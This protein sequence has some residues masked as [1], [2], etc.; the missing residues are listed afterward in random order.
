MKDLL[1]GLIDYLLNEE[2]ILSK[3]LLPVLTFVAALLALMAL[4]WL[5]PGAPASPESDQIDVIRT[6]DIPK[7]LSPAVLDSY[8]AV[9][10][11]TTQPTPAASSRKKKA[12][13]PE[14]EKVESPADAI[15]SSL[16]GQSFDD[17]ALAGTPQFDGA[18]WA[19]ENLCAISRLQDN[20]GK[21]ADQARY[22]VAE[23]K[24][25]CGIF[26]RQTARSWLTWKFGGLLGWPLQLLA[27]LL[28]L[29]MGALTLWVWRTKQRYHWL[30][31]SRVYRP[32]GHR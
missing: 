4:G 21:F 1:R 25:G 31:R 19:S 5:P 32:Q 6:S 8:I 13:L 11:P 30:Y 16:I 23:G 3:A 29:G 15:R 28:P 14:P 2:S 7:A 27:L 26:T 10:A 24:G 9:A 12:A 18:R 22:L 20:W 17:K